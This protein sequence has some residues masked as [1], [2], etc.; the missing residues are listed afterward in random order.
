MNAKL[1]KMQKVELREIFK[2]EASDFTPWLAQEDNIALLGEVLGLELEVQQQ[3]AN[4]G[5]FRADI[6]CKEAQ[7]GK[8]VLVE[9]QI[10]PTDHG[11]LGQLL[12]YAGGLDAAFVVWVAQKFAEE[13]RA[14]L[15]WL[16]EKFEGVEDAPGF[17][18]VEVELWRIGNSEPAPRFNIVAKPNDWSTS[19][20]RVAREAGLTEKE[21]MRL[22]YWSDLCEYLRANRSSL[23]PNSAGAR[24]WIGLKRPVKNF[25][26]GFWTA[27]DC[28][29][30]YT[31]YSGEEA[32]KLVERIREKYGQD[33]EREVGG[34]VDWPKAASEGSRYYLT[35]WRDADPSDLS[36][37]PAQHQRL[38]ET[39][40]KFAR[41]FPKH[42]ELVS[43]GK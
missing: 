22:K 35:V 24:K 43:K 25:S 18:G 28:I 5:P 13:H 3:E 15:N 40:E 7:S 8:A 1:G 29:G 34:K 26:F 33:F 2:N 32:I 19:V 21:Q 9:N 16:N 36:D 23:Q 4:V 11:H 37:W 38:K 14:A 12:T 39:G 10:E 31:G 42:I 41:A 27:S 6:L 20:K 30:V 17:F